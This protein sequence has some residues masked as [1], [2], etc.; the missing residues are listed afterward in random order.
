MPK[1]T[2]TIP[3][4]RAGEIAQTFQQEGLEVSFRGPLENSTG[5]IEDEA[6]EIVYDLKKVDDG[7]AWDATE[8]AAWRATEA[9]VRKIRR[10]LPSVEITVED[11]G[12]VI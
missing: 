2:M 7:A 1:V 4:S 11:D 5:G 12:G 6:V 9:A 3:S 10:R 8:D